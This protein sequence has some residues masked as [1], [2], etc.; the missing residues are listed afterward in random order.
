MRARRVCVTGGGGYVGS[1]LVP[2]L[3]AKGFSVT[4]LD[5]FWY[6]DH[7]QAHPSLKKI[8]GDIR[9]RNHLREAFQGQDIVIHLACVSNDPSFDMNPLLG[10]QINYSCFQD[11]LSALQQNHVGRFIYA[12]SSSVYGV[13]ELPDVTEDSPKNP[14]TDYSKFKLACENE[15][16]SFGM[17]GVWTI[18]RPATVCG[19]APRLRLDLVVNILTTQAMINKKITLFGKTQKRPNINV[20]DMIRAYSFLLDA[21]E[22]DVD[23]QTYNV[24]FQNMTLWQIACLVKEVVGEDV[25]IIEEPTNDPRSYHV[26]SDKIRSIGFGPEHTI[27][28]AI[29]SLFKA[30]Y[31]RQLI[32]PLDNPNYY[33]IKKMKELR[34]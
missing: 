18:V 31:R 26:N 12:S 5:T 9:S 32:N 19:Y 34:L 2:H 29:G 25:E 1:A 15:L 4:V 27:V 22:R 8:K 30:N 16:K 24:G 20:Q 21:D 6:G 10:R 11:I 33:N 28:D 14:L 17:G 23:Q 7:L 13:S 3:L